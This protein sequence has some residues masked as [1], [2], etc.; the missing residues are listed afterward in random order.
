ML[1]RVYTAALLGIDGFE[2]TVECSAL[3]KLPALEIIG[4]PD[5]AVKE[6]RE[7]IRAAT[8][9]SGIRFPSLEMILN[10][11]PANR[12]KE[13][14]SF[15]LAMI[16]SVLCC[17]E[18]VPADGL[19]DKCFIGE[20]S[21]SGEVRAV[22]GVLCMCLAAK[23]K[24]R[25][26]MFVP[27][28]NAPEASAVPD[29]KV[30]P[31]RDL[32]QLVKHLRGEELIAPLEF[33]RTVFEKGKKHF[34][35][36]FADVKGQFLPKRALEIAAAGGHNVLLIGPP[37]TGKSM[38][39]KRF[40][41]ILPELSFDEAIE[42]TKIHSIAGMLDGATQLI[43]NRPFRS[44]HH[45]MSAVSLVGGGTNP[46]PGEVSLSHNG[47]LFLDELPEYSRSVIE[48][49]RQPLED[50]EVTITR[51]MAKVTYPANFSLIAAMNPCKCGYFSHPT[52][53][54][55]CRPGEMRKYLSKISGPLLD[56]MD[57]QVEVGPVDYDALRE[58]AKGAETSE[59]VRRRVIEAREFARK[60]CEA[61][62]TP[63]KQNSD[64][65]ASE[66]EKYCRMTDDASS[67][68]RTAFD[69]LGMSARGYDRILK[70][71]RTVADLDKS[72][73]IGPTHIAT[74]ISLR[75]LDKK[76]FNE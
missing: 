55:T 16:V 69:S 68:L 32:L 72:E 31:V 61:G 41:T 30:Y 9:N 18:T 25:K 23:A 1:A 65:C 37:G 2:V 53:Q 33:D 43:V 24:G 73:D 67:L 6:A 75:S 29:V 36:D 19:E 8:V 44:P 49:L 12:K 13:G 35:V 4:L 56:R 63:V 28:A 60:R 62:G 66:I 3:K 11:A 59:T 40:P 50:G 21:L 47:V 58:S 57:I 51:A 54:C 10:L 15:D 71:A 34:D 38:L 17:G 22:D 52:K 5:T 26:E 45:T 14:S 27:A 48:T 46:K 42:T 39:A 74:A 7:R 70:I 76:Y 64:L 20:L